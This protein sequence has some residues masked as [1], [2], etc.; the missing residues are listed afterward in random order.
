MHW[1]CSMGSISVRSQCRSLRQMGLVQVI[2]PANER[3]IRV[4]TWVAL[5]ASVRTASPKALRLLGDRVL[6]P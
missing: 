1:L 6:R 2:G 4:D 5:L 3:R